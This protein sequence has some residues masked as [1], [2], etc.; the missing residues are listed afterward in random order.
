MQVHH[1]NCGTMHPPLRRLTNGDGGWREPGEFVCHVLLLETNYELALVDTGIGEIDIQEPK[2]RLGKNLL[3]FA[4][5]VLD[6]RETAIVQI[7]EL[8]YDPGDVK[9]LILTHLDCD[10]AGGLADF[11]WAEVVTSPRMAELAVPRVAPELTGR[12]QAAQWQHG[13]LWGHSEPAPDWF[14]ISGVRE[15]VGLA[16]VLLVPLEGHLPGHVGVAVHDGDGW[17]LHAGDAFYHRNSLAGRR[18]PRGVA[19][20]E[21]IA[22]SDMLSWRMSV[23]RLRELAE[24]GVRVVNAHDPALLGQPASSTARANSR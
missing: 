13:P 14:G 22:R 3:R 15:V 24:A 1:L 12:L 8:G 10:H 21:A 23:R 2:R 20:F 11:R 4:R 9:H 16:G 6:P 5:P 18:V 19:A 17:L 7:R